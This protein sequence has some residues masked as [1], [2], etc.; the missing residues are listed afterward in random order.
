M[1]VNIYGVFLITGECVPVE[2]R[3]RRSVAARIARVLRR[4]MA[5]PAGARVTLVEFILPDGEIHTRCE[6]RAWSED[7]ERLA[8]AALA[9]TLRTVLEQ[10]LGRLTKAQARR[11]G[12]A[13]APA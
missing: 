6:I 1:C 12:S 11:D 9:P 13:V 3:L 8:V 2:T 10:S 4:A 5:H 7:G